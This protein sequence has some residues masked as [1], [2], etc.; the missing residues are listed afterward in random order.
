MSLW[1]FI[2]SY[3]LLSGFEESER[4]LQRFGG[5]QVQ[6]V[7]VSAGTDLIFFIVVGKMLCFGFKIRIT[8]ITHWCFWTLLTQH[9]SLFSFLCCLGKKELGCARS[10][11]MHSQDSWCKPIRVIFHAVWDHAQQENWGYW[12]GGQ[13][14]PRDWLGTGQWVTNDVLL[15]CLCLHPRVLSVFQFSSS[16]HCGG[17]SKWLHDARLSAR[18]N[19]NTHIPE[20][21]FL[22][23][24]KGNSRHLSS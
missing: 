3:S 9:Q 11:G 15:N 1:S 2:Y 8:L 4:H 20:P 5:W 14:L 13:L 16:H 23:S 19:H 24:Q 12:S 21:T 22:M 7:P 6:S 17:L 18:L 10:W